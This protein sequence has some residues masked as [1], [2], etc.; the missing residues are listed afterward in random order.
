MIEHINGVGKFTFTNS[1]VV[2]NPILVEIT[3]V[4]EEYKQENNI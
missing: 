2:R 1:D 3:R 4:W